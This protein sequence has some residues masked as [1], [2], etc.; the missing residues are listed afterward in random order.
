MKLEEM[1]PEMLKRYECSVEQEKKQD[2]EMKTKQAENA[3]RLKVLIE[4][5]IRTVR[6]EIENNMQ[7][8]IYGAYA[9]F[10]ANGG[11]SENPKGIVICELKDENGF[12]M[13]VRFNDWRSDS[14]HHT[15][16]IEAMRQFWDF[17]ADIDYYKID[18]EKGHFDLVFSLNEN[19][20]VFG[21]NMWLANWSEYTPSSKMFKT[22]V[23]SAFPEGTVRQ[24]NGLYKLKLHMD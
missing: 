7:E 11:R 15:C 10:R 1:I 14:Y 22:I 18:E 8:D 17:L 3:Q 20:V 23:R 21:W 13:K 12:T 2:E 5:I 16:K 4:S 6:L 9:R 19:L 24:S